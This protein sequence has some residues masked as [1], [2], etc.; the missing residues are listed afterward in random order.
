MEKSQNGFTNLKRF[1]YRASF[2]VDNTIEFRNR[3]V[4]GIMQILPYDG[5]SRKAK[6]I[7]RITIYIVLF[8]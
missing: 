8:S 4:F 7:I 6:L 5:L 2:Q 3:S 1:K